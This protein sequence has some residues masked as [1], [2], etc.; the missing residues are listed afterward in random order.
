L[1]VH[2]PAAL[3]ENLSGLSSALAR[4]KGIVASVPETIPTID[5]AAWEGKVPADKLAEIKTQYEGMTFPEPVV[6]GNGAAVASFVEHYSAAISPVT[7]GSSGLLTDLTNLKAKFQEDLITMDNWE[8]EDWAR[9]F[10]GFIDKVRARHLVGDIVEDDHTSKYLEIDSKALAEDVRAGKQ[11]NPSMPEDVNEYY[12]GGIA[13]EGDFPN[14]P[15]DLLEKLTA[16]SDDG[17]SPQERSNAAYLRDY[18]DMWN[19]L[20]SQIAPK[21]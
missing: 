3:R 21:E 5:W 12:F 18:G 14:T 2:S 13:T 8:P 7:E 1:T 15:K 20:F 16:V 6:S 10:P 19:S 11:I 17:L 4:N 9:R